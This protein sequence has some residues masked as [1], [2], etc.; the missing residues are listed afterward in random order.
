M[1]FRITGTLPAPWEDFLP[2]DGRFACVTIHGA[3]SRIEQEADGLVE[4][5]TPECPVVVVPEPLVTLEVARR[6]LGTLVGMSPDEIEIREAG[7]A[8]AW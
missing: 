4:E 1:V 6:A 3:V 5:S 2:E 7:I 8:Q